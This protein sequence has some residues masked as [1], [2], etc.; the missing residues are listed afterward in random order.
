[1]SGLDHRLLNKHAFAIVDRLQFPEDECPAGL[2]VEPLVP[3]RLAGSARMLPGLVSLRSLSD[4]LAATC[5]N[6]L[7]E[8]AAMGGALLFSALLKADASQD[9]MARH[10]MNTL[11]ATAPDRDLYLRQFDPRLFVQ[12]D[13]LL[14]PPQRVRLFGPITG[15]TLY[16]DNEWRTFSPPSNVKPAIGWR[17]TVEQAV[18]IEALQQINRA[19]ASLS[20]GGIDLRRDRVRSGY[21]ML[22][23]ARR[24]GLSTER[25]LVRFLEHGWAIH[26]DF[27]RHPEVW[28]RL[29]RMLPAD[30]FPYLAATSDLDS[31]A[32][33]RIRDDMAKGDSP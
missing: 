27:D 28:S 10:F 14:T 24:H 21:S 25:C 32:L 3:Q 20:A 22:E 9:A 4:D 18:R 31:A 1:M 29:E 19:M 12:Y 7:D 23:R 8:Q 16:L 33:A 30:D 15:W 26:P 17:L 11:V 6:L 2:H 5:L 13:W